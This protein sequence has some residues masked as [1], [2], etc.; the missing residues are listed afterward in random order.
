MEMNNMKNL[1]T[2]TL[3]QY[4]KELDPEK[5]LFSFENENFEEKFLH[6]EKN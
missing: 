3:E 4:S 2:E 1:I 6:M 5:N